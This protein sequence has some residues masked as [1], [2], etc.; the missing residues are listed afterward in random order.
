[1][2]RY[3]A[4]DGILPAVPQQHGERRVAKVRRR[5]ASAGRV[6]GDRLRRRVTASPIPRGHRRSV[7][8]LARQ[9]H[10]RHRGHHGIRACP[11]RL[12]RAKPRRLAVDRAGRL[13][14]LEEEGDR[15]LPHLRDDPEE[16]RRSAARRPGWGDGNAER[17]GARVRRAACRVR[18]FVVRA[19]A[20][21]GAGRQGPQDGEG[22]PALGASERVSPVPG[23]D[24]LRHLGVYADR[25]RGW[26]RLLRLLLHFG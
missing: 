22:H 10:G 20:D 1:M 12:R 8:Q 13:V 17:R 11:H 2:P 4:G 15:E 26:R 9:R 18:H 24:A 6:R 16:V 21:A 25:A 5:V 14:L 23:R 3:R 7:P 19:P